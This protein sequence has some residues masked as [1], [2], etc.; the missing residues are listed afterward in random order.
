M[1][2]AVVITMTVAFVLIALTA[3]IYYMCHLDDSDV[4][5][6][7]SQATG[8]TDLDSDGA[9]PSTAFTAIPTTK[10]TSVPCV[11]TTQVL[12]HDIS[13]LSIC[14]ACVD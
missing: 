11:K 13:D 3:A 1:H 9:T 7:T 8:D 2:T 6:P 12:S 14:Q 4:A 5:T 10:V